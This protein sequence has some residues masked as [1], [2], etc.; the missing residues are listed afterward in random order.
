MSDIKK[1][2]TV[3]LKSGGPVMTVQI[4]GDYSM[5][6]GIDN[7]AMCVWFDGNKPMEKVF[8]IDS[9]HIDND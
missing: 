5:N 6:H 1:G 2:D 3:R 9:L 8:D 7:G 4:I